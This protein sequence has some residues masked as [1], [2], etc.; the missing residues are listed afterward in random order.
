[1]NMDSNVTSNHVFLVLTNFHDAPPP[2]SIHTTQ[3]ETQLI[4][5]DKQRQDFTCFSSMGGA[6][7]VHYLLSDPNSLCNYIFDSP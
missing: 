7:V 4:G 5:V 1:M 6:N 2:H 3:G